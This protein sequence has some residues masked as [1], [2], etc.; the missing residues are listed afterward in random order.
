MEFL[1]EL[2]TR[3]YLLGVFTTS[4]PQI[5]RRTC[6]ANTSKRTIIDA[7]AKKMLDGGIKKASN[8]SSAKTRQEKAGKIQKGLHT[9]RTCEKFRTISHDV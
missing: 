1:V 6:V 7:T 2:P 5:Q 9:R 8:A 3:I 4:A